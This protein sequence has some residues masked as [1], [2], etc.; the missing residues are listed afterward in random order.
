MWLQVGDFGIIKPS[1]RQ[2]T[3]KPKAAAHTL[4]FRERERKG[5][6]F[7]NSNVS[8]SMKTIMLSI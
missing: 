8:K 5:D 4:N 3:M 6:S 1:A 2:T 7:L